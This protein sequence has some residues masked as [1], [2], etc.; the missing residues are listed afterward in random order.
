MKDTVVSP[1]DGPVKLLDV[2]AVAAMLG[3]STRHVYRLSD[4]AKMPRPMKL[5]T[6]CRWSASAI[7]DWVKADCQS[8]RKMK[9]GAR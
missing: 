8:V 3:C 2:K 6:L 7:R 5:G 4:A 9:G 1:V